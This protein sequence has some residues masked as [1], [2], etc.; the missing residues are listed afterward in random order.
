M[1][2]KRR[3]KT[4]KELP[5]KDEYGNEYLCRAIQPVGV[6]VPWSC[7]S[8]HPNYAYHTG[9]SAHHTLE[10]GK[11]SFLMWLFSGF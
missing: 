6:K 7:A 2:D 8:S 11:T 3:S 5:L 9:Q 10:M 4:L 1:S